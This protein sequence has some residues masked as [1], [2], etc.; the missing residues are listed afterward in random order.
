MPS[1][2]A[3]KRVLEQEPSLL[4]EVQICATCDAATVVLPSPVVPAPPF[5]ALVPLPVVPPAPPPAATVL[6]AGEFTA[7]FTFA[8]ELAVLASIPA[9]EDAAPAPV[10][11]ADEASPVFTASASPLAKA[12][13]LAVLSVVSIEA[14]DAVLTSEKA[15]A[16]PSP[17]ELADTPTLADDDAEAVP[18]VPVLVAELPVLAAA[19]PLI[20]PPPS[21]ETSISAA[22]ADDDCADVSSDVDEVAASAAAS[23]WASPSPDD[24]PLRLADSLEPSAVLELAL[25][26][27][28]AEAPAPLALASECEDVVASPPPAV[29]WLSDEALADAA[30]AAVGVSHPCALGAI[31]AAVSKRAKALVESTSPSLN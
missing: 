16:E 31:G 4:A 27:P 28:L 7:T 12:S 22:A 3:M 17:E 13:V 1:R 11:L 10:A 25:A 26:E 9:S 6:V 14:S 30:R 21:V 23:P 15:A 20:E 2:I 8:A 5:S 29:A 18:S 19:L 24:V